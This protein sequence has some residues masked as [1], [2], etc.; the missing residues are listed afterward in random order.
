MK[1]ITWD[2]IT[3]WDVIIHERYRKLIKEIERFAERRCPHLK[4]SGN[5]LLLWKRPSKKMWT[6]M[7]SHPAIPFIGEWPTQCYFKCTVWKNMK[8]VVYL[9]ANC[10]GKIF[11]LKMFFRFYVLHRFFYA[12]KSVLNMPK[13][14]D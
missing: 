4:K 6:K 8:L 10:H 12:S 11:N 2:N 13:P 1:P 3:S 7:N 14:A 9:L 5:F